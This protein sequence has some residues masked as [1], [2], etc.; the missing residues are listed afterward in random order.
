[1][2][3]VTTTAIVSTSVCIDPIIFSLFFMTSMLGVVLLA[4]F[5][6]A[7]ASTIGTSPPLSF[8]YLLPL[9]EL[10]Y[11][12]TRAL[13]DV[14][15]DVLLNLNNFNEE[16]LRMLSFYLPHTIHGATNVHTFLDF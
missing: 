14:I 2:D 11:E 15:S 10:H 5:S 16:Q 8:G 12:Y 7:Y 13:D 1:M 9:F 6:Y 3:P 4:T